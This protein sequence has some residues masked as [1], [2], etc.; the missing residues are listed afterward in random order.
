MRIELRRRRRALA[1]NTQMQHAR[2]VAGHIAN[3]G[4][5]LCH[6]RFGLYFAND[7]ELDPLPLA[8][9]LMASGKTL[10]Y[11]VIQPSGKLEFHAVTPDSDYCFNRFGIPEPRTAK[12]LPRFSLGVIFMPLV[13]FDE[14]GNRLGM[15]GGYYDRSFPA[16][17]PGRLLIGLAHALQRV[18]E[19][20]RQPW[21]APLD[22]VVTETGFQ[23]FSRRARRFA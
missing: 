5:L 20:P 6:R 1:L 23:A 11:P 19:L 10:A 9:R 12:A 13:A 14:R 22:A 21:D 4:I 3:S 8:Q 2:A 18:P 7:G 17:Q 16:T 15:G